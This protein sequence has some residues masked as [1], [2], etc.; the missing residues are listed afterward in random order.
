MNRFAV[1]LSLACCAALAGCASD[2]R[3]LSPAIE[4]STRVSEIRDDVA[5]LQAQVDAMQASLN[6]LVFSPAADLASQFATFEQNFD[7]TV[8]QASV[9]EDR[10]RQANARGRELVDAWVEQEQALEGTAER[11]T[12]R[13]RRADLAREHELLSERLLA[14]REAL[15][16]YMQDLY[17]TIGFLRPNLNADG[18]AD[19]REMA[20]ESNLHAG[21]IKQRLGEVIEQ[22]D[23]IQNRY[24]TK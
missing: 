21:Q 2:G 4:A 20:E 22:L 10:V 7:A 6:D 1:L 3:R 18:I 15:E 14:T 19:I 11:E 12:S 8:K 23:R 13:Q 9:V 16:S 24:F 17:D 5:G